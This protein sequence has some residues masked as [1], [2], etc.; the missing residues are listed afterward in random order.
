[1]RLLQLL[2]LTIA[3]LSTGLLRAAPV[4][5][6]RAD[7]LDL[8]P[9]ITI[10]EDTQASLSLEDVA[11][12]PETRFAAATPSWPTQAYSRSAFWLKVQLSNSSTAACSRLLV[13][14]APRLEDIR[15]YQP[16]HDAHAGG[17]YPVAEWPQPATRQPAFPVSLPAGRAPRCSSA[18]RATSRCCW[19][20]N[21][22]P[23]RR[24]CAVSNRPT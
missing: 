12:L 8:M 18:W 20:R 5:I 21:C 4:D 17:A 11:Q 3:L 16:G 9:A 23:N 6:C 13:V 10:F 22:G 15:V 14:G 2:L 24:C 19:S 7:H 1:M